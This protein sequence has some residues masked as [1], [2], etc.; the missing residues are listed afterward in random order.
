MY[1]KLLISLHNKLKIKYVKKDHAL[2]H[3]HSFVNENLVN[4][5][6]LLHS[7]SHNNQEHQEQCKLQPCL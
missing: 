1:K 6:K 7:D 5:V 2:K 3:G 4:S